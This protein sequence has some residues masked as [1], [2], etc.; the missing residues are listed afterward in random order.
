MATDNN[1]QQRKTLG[2]LHR[3]Y[4]LEMTKFAERV[5]KYLDEDL[6]P[7]FFI[8]GIPVNHNQPVWIEPSEDS[9]YTSEFFNAIQHLAKEYQEEEIAK[10]AWRNASGN[11]TVEISGRSI[12]KAVEKVLND[13]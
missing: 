5:F 8:L 7:R 2:G 12:Q 4:Q 13:E 1:E 3:V 6:R 10:N 9:G 11:E